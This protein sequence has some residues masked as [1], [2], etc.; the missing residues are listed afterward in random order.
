MTSLAKFLA[1]SKEEREFK[2]R[3]AKKLL[4]QTVNRI[5]EEQSDTS[6]V[7][8]FLNMKLN[9]FDN[10]NILQNFSF[11]IVMHLLPIVNFIILIGNINDVIITFKN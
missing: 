6:F 10:N 5:N 2:K 11:N 7:K 3:I 8:R 4:E 1:T 9:G